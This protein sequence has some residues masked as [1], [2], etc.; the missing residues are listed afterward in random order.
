MT[1][2]LPDK[3]HPDRW[4]HVSEPVKRILDRIEEQRK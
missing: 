3:R 1:T 4:Q 2:P